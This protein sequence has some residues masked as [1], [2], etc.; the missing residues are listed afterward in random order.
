MF[1]LDLKRVLLAQVMSLLLCGPLAFCQNLDTS[2]NSEA[3][4][5]KVESVV[6]KAALPLHLSTSSSSIN[7]TSAQVFIAQEDIQ[8]VKQYG[9]RAVPI[10][11][12][13]LLGPDA[14]KERVALRL[15]GVIGGPKVANPLTLI[16]E[17]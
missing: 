6:D 15:L 3:M 8:Q 10:L 13:Y 9:E 2:N 17:K 16:L 11:S 5:A 12:S 4:K 7:A 14:R 1:S